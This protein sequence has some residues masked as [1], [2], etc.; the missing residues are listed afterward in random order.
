M[1]T[2]LDEFQ[3][4]SLR[5]EIR[6]EFVG[7]ELWFEDL[8]VFAPQNQCLDFWGKVGDFVAGGVAPAVG[9]VKEGREGGREGGRGE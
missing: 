1:T 6:N 5:A 8:V 2:F 9:G 3:L 7:V 4:G